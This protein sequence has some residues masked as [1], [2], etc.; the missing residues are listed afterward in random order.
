M[1]SI[2]VLLQA[3]TAHLGHCKGYCVSGENVHNILINPNF[4]NRIECG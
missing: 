1:T 3:E 2:N 4:E